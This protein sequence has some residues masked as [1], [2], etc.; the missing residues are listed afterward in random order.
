MSDEE[1]EQALRELRE[2]EPCDPELCGA[3]DLHELCAY[4]LERAAEERP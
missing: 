4:L 2:A 1:W 3:C